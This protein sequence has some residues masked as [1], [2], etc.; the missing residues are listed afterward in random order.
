MD[1]IINWTTASENNMKKLGFS[2]NT[3]MITG[4]AIV[5]YLVYRLLLQDNPLHLSISAII[6]YSHHLA[7]KQHL[8]LIALLPV[9]V[10]SIIFGATLLGLYLGSTLQ[11][12]L[13]RVF[14]S[15]RQ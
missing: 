3:G 4:L 14:P 11:G 1:A 5:L 9:Y 7:T 12:V 2:L 15:H 13:V 8:I 10:A 6:T